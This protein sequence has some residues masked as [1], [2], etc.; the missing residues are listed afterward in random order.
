MDSAVRPEL[1]SLADDEAVALEPHHRVD[2][3]FRDGKLDGIGSGDSIFMRRNFLDL[4]PGSQDMENINTLISR[5]CEVDYYP[6]N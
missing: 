5:G 4:T 3:P 2:R 1:M 6:Q